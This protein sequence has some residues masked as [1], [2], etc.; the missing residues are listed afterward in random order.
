MECKKINLEELQT[1][2]PNNSEVEISKQ[3]LNVQK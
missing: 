2:N 1:Q 3:P